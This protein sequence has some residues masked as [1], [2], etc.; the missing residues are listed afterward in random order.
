MPASPRRRLKALPEPSRLKEAFPSA[1]QR[2]CN[3]LK[4]EKHVKYDRWAID[5]DYLHKLSEEEK[6]WLSA[7]TEEYHR[8]WWLKDETQVNSTEA[9][10]KASTEHQQR[11][12]RMPLGA[13]TVPT[14]AEMESAARGIQQHELRGRN[15]VEDEMVR[16][17]DRP[18]RVK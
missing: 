18:K 1:R 10:R 6:I 5:Y 12:R 9:L 16:W 17:L 11:R 4:V 7:F 3:G 14:D 8:G 15:S 2:K 13:T